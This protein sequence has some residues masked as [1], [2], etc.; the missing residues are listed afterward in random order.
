MRQCVS[1]LSDLE[2]EACKVYADGHRLS[3][4]VGQTLHPQM[5]VFLSE[6]RQSARLEAKTEIESKRSVRW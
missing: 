5:T 4:S 2:K 1:T 6:V 3:A